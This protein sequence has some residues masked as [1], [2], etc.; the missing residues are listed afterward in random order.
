MHMYTH[1]LKPNN[2][3]QGAHLPKDSQIPQDLH[4]SSLHQRKT[5]PKK[6][7]ESGSAARWIVKDHKQPPPPHTP[8]RNE[9]Q[10]PQVYQ[11]QPRSQI[12]DRQLVTVRVNDT[13]PQS[14]PFPTPQTPHVSKQP[15]ERV[16]KINKQHQYPT[17]F[18]RITRFS[19]V[20]FL[21]QIL[22]DARK[23]V[24]L[25]GGKG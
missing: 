9:P 15:P 1:V 5:V 3:R 10:A 17:R 21:Y 20:S 4:G 23:P 12:S 14:F 8:Q 11:L 22:M 24:S 18:T 13:V 6:T 25:S 19:K 2:T 7:R 16:K